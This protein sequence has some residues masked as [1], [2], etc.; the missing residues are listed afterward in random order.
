M[1]PILEG[2]RKELAGRLQ[3]EFVDVAK[4]KKAAE[5]YKIDTIPTQ[6]FFDASGKELFRHVGFFSRDA[7]LAKWT[8][9][10]V[11]VA[12]KVSRLVREEPVE[13]DTRPR[14]QV[15]SLCEKTID[16][17]TNVQV[18]APWGKASLC[19]VHCYAIYYSSLRDA[20]L[21]KDKVTV[22]DAATGKRVPAEKAFYLYAFK[23]GGR[24]AITAYE[25]V[26]AAK[27]AAPQG[28]G[29]VLTL[30]DLLKKEL[31]ARCGFCDRAVYP[32]D[33][34]TVKAEGVN[35]YGCCPMCGLG[36]VARLKKDIELVQKDALTGDLVKVTTMDL[37]L[38]KLEPATAVGWHGQR[39]NKEGKMASSGCFHQ[40]LFANEENF[41]KWL[42]QHPEESG[43]LMTIEQA[44][45]DKMK[46]SPEQ[47]KNAC[48]IGEC[49]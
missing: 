12:V 1:A 38:G 48:K 37:S 35:T 41:K 31:A 5:Q 4:D 39:K 9:L 15:C 7:I 14:E 23:E 43:K 30:D 19:S 44:L 27:A 33:A 34:C 22:A 45:A 25:T 6:I 17:K 49:K 36:V 29:Q 21:V 20:S 3:V 11:D 26:E 47:I 13:R 46:M 40:F 42:E 2:L 18:D 8:E 24:P 28:Q 16:P 32:E 10:G